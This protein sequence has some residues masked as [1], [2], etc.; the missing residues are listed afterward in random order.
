MLVVG[1]VQRLWALWDVRLRGTFADVGLQPGD[2]D[3]LAG[4]HRTEGPA[5]PGDLARAVLVTAGATTKRV[6]RLVDAGLAERVHGSADG[7]HRLVQLTTRGK[8]LAERLMAAHLGNEAQLLSVLSPAEQQQLQG[9]LAKL[10]AAAEHAAD[11][12][13]S[14][15]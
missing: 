5:A 14:P 12:P 1:R 7:R 13:P 10:L 11:Q 4:L 8:E 3:I 2:F 9:L 6:D 15:R